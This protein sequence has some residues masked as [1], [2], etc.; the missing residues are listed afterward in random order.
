MTARERLVHDAMFHARVRAVEETLVRQNDIE[1][2]QGLTSVTS[3]AVV[4]HAHD[5]MMAGPTIEQMRD[6]RER[7]AYMLRTFF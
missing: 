4:L 1:A 2:G 7:E 3:V 6:A 5:Q